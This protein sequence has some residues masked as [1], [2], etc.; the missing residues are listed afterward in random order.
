VE[1]GVVQY[2]EAADKE[3]RQQ[4]VLKPLVEHFGVTVPLKEHGSQRLVVA[5]AADE[6]GARALLPLL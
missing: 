1:S 5:V 2:D 6:T 3:L 4:H